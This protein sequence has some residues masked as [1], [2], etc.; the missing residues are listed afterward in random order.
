MKLKIYERMGDPDLENDIEALLNDQVTLMTDEDEIMKE[1]YKVKA[2]T[3]N[4]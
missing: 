2:M 3:R 1:Y 4:N